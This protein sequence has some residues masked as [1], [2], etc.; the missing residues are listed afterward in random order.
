MTTYT[1]ET[2][3][4][5]DTRAAKALTEYMTVLDDLPEVPGDEQY[6][7]ITQSGSQYEVDLGGETCSCPD[8]EYRDVECKHIHRVRYALGLEEVPEWA[9]ESEIDPR[10]GEHVSTS[11]R[12]TTSAIS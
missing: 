7:V 5:I 6:A 12:L 3:E 1:C 8:H 11:R 9:D 4:S 2:Q 10:L